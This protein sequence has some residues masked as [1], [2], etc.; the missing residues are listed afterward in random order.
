MKILRIT[1]FILGFGIMAHTAFAADQ[2]K[3]TESEV[4]DS[5][6]SVSTNQAYPFILYIGDNLTGVTNPLKSLHYTASGVYTGSGTV[7]FMIDG[8]VATTKTFTLPNVGATTTPFEIDY[9]DTS[10]KINP[11]S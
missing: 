6:V 9:K 5:D 10:N 8:D 4:A 2:M 7:T 3:T 11:T 1:L